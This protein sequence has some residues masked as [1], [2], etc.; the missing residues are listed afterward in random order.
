[1]GSRNKVIFPLLVVLM[2]ISSFFTLI[3]ILI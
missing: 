1:M 3:V 2:T